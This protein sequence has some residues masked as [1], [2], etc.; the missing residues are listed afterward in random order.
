M[1]ILLAVA[2][3]VWCLWECTR[4]DGAREPH[5]YLALGAMLVTALIA[6]GPQ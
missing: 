1:T 4:P 5:I 2:A 6:G 3:F